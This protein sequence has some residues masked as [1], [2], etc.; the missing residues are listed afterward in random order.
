MSRNMRERGD[1]CQPAYHLWMIKRDAESNCASER[2]PNQQR[3]LQ[4]QLADEF[5]HDR[6]LLCKPP[7]RT[8]RSPGITGTW[9]VHQDYA[10]FVR[11]PFEQGVG[12]V[13]HL[14]AEAVENHDGR[15]RTFIQVVNSCACNLDE[16]TPSGQSSFDA[17]RGNCSEN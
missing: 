3:P 9:P 15:A 13:A 4:P 11:Q 16:L 17:T 14:P 10:K 6:G 2:V 7:G 1:E 5:R 8:G 12:K